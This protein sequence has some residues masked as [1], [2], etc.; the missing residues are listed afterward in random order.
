LTHGTSPVGDGLTWR[1]VAFNTATAS[2]NKI[3]DDATAARFGFSGGLVPGVD[4]F[5]YMTHPPRRRF[6]AQWLSRGRM[7]ARFIS[8]TYDGRE[9]EAS[10]RETN[11]G[12][13]DLSLV[14][15]GRTCATG[16]A[17]L[18]AE[19]P[20]AYTLPRADAPDRSERPPASPES[21]P[22]GAVLGSLEEVY[23]AAAGLDYILQVR[24]DPALYDDGRLVHPGWLLRRANQILETNVRLGP[25]IH[26]ESDLRL[27]AQAHHGAVMETRGCVV[28]NRD[29]KGHRIVDMDV[30][31][32]ADG[33]LAAMIR[34]TAIY[35]PRQ[36]R[37]AS[38]DP[39][40]QSRA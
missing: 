23:T 13:L 4:V 18:S 24:D 20:P 10:A 40:A 9:A 28:D 21:L 2:E 25:W 36:V 27:F 1:V 14:S 37:M 30:Q 11:P 29:T 3:H 32:L 15:E 34:H 39:A 6:G 12:V 38:G 19:P 35:E 31:L 22:P 8:P 7:Q 5:A 26:V 33:Q 16:Q 17:S